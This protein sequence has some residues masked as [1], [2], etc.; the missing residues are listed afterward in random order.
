MEPQGAQRDRSRNIKPKCQSSNDK[1]N[2]NDSMTN[3]GDLGMGI[4]PQSHRASPKGREH[5]EGICEWKM[6]NGE[7]RFLRF[8]RPPK[9]DPPLAENYMG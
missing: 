8:G 5:R 1:S 6:E 9:V 2:P 3:E 7:W 4:E